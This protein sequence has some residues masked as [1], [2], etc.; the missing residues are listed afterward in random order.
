[1]WQIKFY[2]P[3]FQG[4]SGIKARNLWLLFGY[5]FDFL[6]WRDRGVIV[7]RNWMVTTPLCTAT[8]KWICNHQR[9]RSLSQ[10]TKGCIS[11]S[12][13]R[14]WSQFRLHPESNCSTD[15]KR[16]AEKENE[17]LA[18]LGPA[19]GTLGTPRYFKVLQGTPTNYNLSPGYR[20]AVRSPVDLWL[21][22][23]AD[24]M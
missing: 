2:A 3:A 12:A 15:T 8:E 11:G 23:T 4:T 17:W 22:L 16:V 19:P 1:M 18:I 6:A 7:L 9:A 14:H 20:T 10:G 5:C 13:I 21:Q 24:W